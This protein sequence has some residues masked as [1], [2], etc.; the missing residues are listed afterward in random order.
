MTEYRAVHIKDGYVVSA[1]KGH[2]M[3]WFKTFPHIYRLETREVTDWVPVPEGPWN[4][5]P[6][7]ETK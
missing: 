4:D 3:G 6:T 2:P 5:A 7:Q 1:E